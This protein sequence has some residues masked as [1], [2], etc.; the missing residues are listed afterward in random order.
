MPA[1]EGQRP[2]RSEADLAEVVDVL[3]DDER[4]PY[5][6]A[7]RYKPRGL[8]KRTE[9]KRSWALQG[10]EDAVAA[11]LGTTTSPRGPAGRRD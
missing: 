4:V 7:H 8:E 5:P 1:G 2:D 3:V 6:P 11:Q 9:W 10:L